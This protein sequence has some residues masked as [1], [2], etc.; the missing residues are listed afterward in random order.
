M[1]IQATTERS[2]TLTLPPKQARGRLR[3]EQVIKAGLQ[4]METTT[5]DDLKMTEL[6]KAA[7]CSVGN[8]YKRFTNKEALLE[9]LLET[10]R[11]RLEGEINQLLS[12]SRSSHWTLPEAVKEIIGIQVRFCRNF[13]GIA[14]TMALYQL[15][16][17]GSPSGNLLEIREKLRDRSVALVTPL[18]PP[19]ENPTDQQRKISFAFQASLGSLIEMTLFK[20]GDFQIDDGETTN[21][22]VDLTLA[23]LQA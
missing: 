5:L 13:R 1:E 18:L 21:R 4:L 16:N 12:E 9:V 22:I 15:K 2:A 8:L 7:G 11:E 17:P 6:A 3:Q 20:G 23:Y 10:V 19:S 14:R